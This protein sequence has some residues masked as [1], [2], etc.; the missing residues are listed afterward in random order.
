MGSFMTIAAVATLQG[1]DH[2]LNTVFKSQRIVNTVLYFISLCTLYYFSIISVLTIFF[3][4][5]KRNYLGTVVSSVFQVDLL[6][7]YSCRL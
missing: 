1:V 3:S 5:V 4:I 7:F 6:K 2:F